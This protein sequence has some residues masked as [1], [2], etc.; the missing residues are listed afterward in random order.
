MY[1]SEVIDALKSNKPIVALESTIISHGMPYPQNLETAIMIENI[2][3]DHKCVP[4]TIAVLDGI[5]HV[6]L[7]KDELEKLAKLGHQARKCSRRDLAFVTSQGLTGATTVSGTMVIAHRAGIKVF[8]TGG[9]GG[10]HR[11]GENK[12]SRTPVAVVCAGVKSILD[13]EKTLEYLETQGVTVATFGETDDFPAFF[14]PKSGLKSP[15]HLKTIEDYANS[16]LKLESGML[17]AVPVPEHESADAN[18]IQVAIDQS[19]RE[20]FDKRIHGKDVTPFLLKRVNEITKGDSL[21][22]NIALIKNNAKKSSSS[23]SNLNNN[24]NSNENIVEA[25]YK[26]G[27]N[28]TFVSTI[29]DDLFGRWIL[30]NFKKVGVIL[31]DSSTAIYSAIHDSSGELFCAIA[32]MK[33]F[34]KISYNQVKEL[35]DPHNLPKLICFD[36][37]PT[38]DCIYDI[39]DLC[40]E[41]NIPAFFEPTS[42]SKSI[43]ILQNPAK[44]KSLI[45][46]NTLK[47][48]SPNIHEI[49]KMYR[50]L[51]IEFL[52][53]VE[54][55]EDVL[56]NSMKFLS[57]IPNIIIKLGK[58]GVLS[59]QYLRSDNNI[60]DEKL[61]RSIDDF[62]IEILIKDLDY[63]IRIKHFKPKFIPHDKIINVTGAGDSFVGALISGLTTFKELSKDN[64]YN[65]WDKLI[66]LGQK[67]ALLSLQSD[68]SVSDEITPDLIKKMSI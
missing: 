22:S 1:N 8:V 54:L 33:I 39:L 24:R 44:F 51:D 48:I 3:R 41:Y 23:I 14:T 57:Y 49:K 55:E 9:I 20:T 52:R 32:D 5:V 26:L 34:D 21:K 53:D 15:S 50:K 10:V 58:S 60:E 42:I 46:T 43:K 4:A 31:N 68:K 62:G 29:G 12:L 27:L 56:F 36:G 37:N 25:C 67:I 28:P 40:K 6:G 63:S 11:D 66:N 64:Q 17:I 59:L 16:R 30:E 18:K 38:V 35:I 45:F 13:I 7:T 61:I 2:I 47:Y 65:S 19:L